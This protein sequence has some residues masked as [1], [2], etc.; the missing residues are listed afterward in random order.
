MRTGH[1]FASR[2]QAGESVLTDPHRCPIE[3]LAVLAEAMQR[4]LDT[5]GDRQAI[6]D[7]EELR[8]ALQRVE[9][10]QEF[11]PDRFDRREANRQLRALAQNRE[12]K[13]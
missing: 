11:Q 1:P 3:D 8:E 5:H 4:L 9:A 7:L 13:Q 6:G 12:I 10:Y 2:Y